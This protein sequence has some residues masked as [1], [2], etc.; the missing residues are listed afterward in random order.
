MHSIIFYQDYLSSDSDGTIS[1]PK[2]FLSGP[3][4]PGPHPE[5]LALPDPEKVPESLGS[6]LSALFIESSTASLMMY[7]ALWRM[8]SFSSGSWSMLAVHG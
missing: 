3:S 1:G 6:A 7:P 8:V 2:G 5:T 4:S